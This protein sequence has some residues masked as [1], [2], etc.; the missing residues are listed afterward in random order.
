MTANPSNSAFSISPGAAFIDTNCTGCNTLTPRGALVERFTATLAGGEPAPVAWSLSAGDPVTGPGTISPDGKYTPPAYLTASRV[1]VVVR[2]TLNSAAVATSVLTLTPGFLQPLTPE[3]AALGPNGSATITALLAEAGGDSTVRFAL[4]GRANGEGQGLGTLSAPTCRRG[5]QS[6]T[7]C[8]VTY[9]APPALG[10][11]AAAWVVATAGNSSSK[12]A[13][14]ILLN[15]AGISSSPALHQA[16]PPFPIRLG[17][18]GGNNN[19]YDARGHRVADCCGG[20]LGSLVQDSAGHQYILGNNHVLARSD[21]AAVGDPIVQPGL[22]DNNCTPLGEGPGVTP[23]AALSAWL[24]LNSSATNADAAI[25]RAASGAVDPDG[26]ILELG[27]R[28]PD[29]TLAAAPPGVSS[30]GGR[31]LAASLGITAAKS[32]RTTGL[33]CGAVAA[34]DLDVSV[35]YYTDCAETRPYLTRTFTGQFA[36][37]GNQFTDAGDSGALIVDA[38][39]A[40]PVGLYFTGGIDAA[41]VS[42]AIASPATGV[43]TELGAQA[44]GATFTFVGGPDHAVSCLNYGDSSLE[45][46]QAHALSAQESARVQQALTQ[47]RALVNPAGGILGVAMGKSSDHP[48]EGAVLVEVDEHA[49]VGVPRTIG[50]VRTVVIPTD[51]RSVAAGLAPQTPFDADASG[52]PSLAAAALAQAIAAKRQISAALMRQNPAYFAVGVG[53]SL[54]NPK[55]AALVVYVDRRLAPAELPETIAGLRTRFILMDRL[56]VTRSYAVPSAPARRCAAQPSRRSAFDALRRL[57]APGMPL[58]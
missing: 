23:V 34:V 5:P 14:E 6:F 38:S 53:Q 26:S 41:G 42:H 9:S 3:N 44:G 39:T 13:A 49:S 21:H 46:A 2:A 50:G 8:T 56:H 32:G 58:P 27:A 29:G 51:A 22:I 11:T 30:T 40:E 33:T 16:Q 57:A 1:E 17:A 31:G 43:L 54:D 24:P 4:A 45:Y 15:T 25:A 12:T 18:S 35:D 47:S 28:Q 36:V 52:A 48:G 10:A 37:S 19:D 20:T 7:T 55:E